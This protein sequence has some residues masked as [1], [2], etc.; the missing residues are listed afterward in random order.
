MM[1]RRRTPLEPA[2]RP[3]AVL[4][5]TGGKNRS[6]TAPLFPRWVKHPRSGG[7]G[8]Q[9]GESFSKRG[10]LAAAG[11]MTATAAFGQVPVGNPRVTLQT[12]LGDITL[13]LAADK[14]PISAANF[15]RYANEKRLDG[16]AFYRALRL[17]G[18]P[19]VG[20]IQGGVQ[21]DPARVLPPI[22]HESTAKTGLKHTD[23]V[24]SL[25]RFAPGTATCDFF[26]CVGDQPSLDADP[27]ASGDNE[28]F[29]AFGHVVQGMET[30]RAIL[31]APV[32]PTKGEGV[33]K[34]QMLDPTVAI[35]TARR[36]G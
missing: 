23:G 36:V 27:A 19:P 14:A 9:L 18:P 24:I 10:L 15:L 31:V 16:A 35:V 2:A 13:E 25:A 22:A 6:R 34:G 17:G 12:A 30:V 32:S 4:P 28:G 7:W 21:G 29:A 8:L 11:A 26:I 3:S 20:L 1:G 5:P 33:M